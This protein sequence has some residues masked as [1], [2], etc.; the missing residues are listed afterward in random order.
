MEGWTYTG[1]TRINTSKR[2]PDGLMSGVVWF[3]EIFRDWRWYVM[4]N[5]DGQVKT[6][7]TGSAKSAR[8]C[9]EIV[10]AM[11]NN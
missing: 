7:G 5:I 1:D 6:I 9:I 2:T 4:T 8:Q 3:H 11:M 10:H